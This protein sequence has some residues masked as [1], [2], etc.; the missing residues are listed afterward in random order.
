MSQQPGV[1]GL[2]QGLV[3]AAVD[4]TAGGDTTLGIAGIVGLGTVF[5]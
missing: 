4:E 1:P 3:I 5:T 2:E